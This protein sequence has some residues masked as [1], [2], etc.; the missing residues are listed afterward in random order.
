MWPPNYGDRK[1]FKVTLSKFGKTSRFSDI[2]GKVSKHLKNISFD[3]R[4]NDET[5]ILN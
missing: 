3:K 1:I 4:S 5:A 2:F